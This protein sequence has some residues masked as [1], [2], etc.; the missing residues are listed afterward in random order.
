MFWKHKSSFQNSL[1]A[2]LS[3]FSSNLW[4][5]PTVINPLSKEIFVSNDLWTLPK[6]KLSP[7]VQSNSIVSTKAIRL[8]Q[9]SQTYLLLQ[10]NLYCFFLIIKVIHAYGRKYMKYKPVGRKKILKACR[11]FAFL[12]KNACWQ[13]YSFSI[14]IL[15]GFSISRRLWWKLRKSKRGRTRSYAQVTYSI[16]S[17][18]SYYQWIKGQQMFYISNPKSNPNFVEFYWKAAEMN[19]QLWSWAPYRKL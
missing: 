13:M 18:W 5:S 9:L 14:D 16:V 6:S 15:R 11:L 8:K 2:S 1:S 7:F 4:C 10:N 17:E 12:R 3:N 19:V